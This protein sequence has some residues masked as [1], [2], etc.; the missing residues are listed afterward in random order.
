MKEQ[1]ITA[2][3]GTW[4]CLILANTSTIPWFWII[5]STMWS[6]RYIYLSLFTK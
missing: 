4:A 5:L 1:R 2:F 3:I 6:I